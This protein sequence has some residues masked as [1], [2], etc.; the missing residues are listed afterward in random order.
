MASVKRQR[1]VADETGQTW[2]VLSIAVG[3]SAA[4]AAKRG[5]HG[6]ELGL[7]QAGL[8]SRRMVYGLCVSNSIGRCG[9]RRLCILLRTSSPGLVRWDGIW[10]LF[11]GFGVITK[12]V[13]NKLTST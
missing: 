8:E 3:Q 2:R 13:K 11:H 6:D 7:G 12:V 9:G 4:A 10:A 5:W 1:M